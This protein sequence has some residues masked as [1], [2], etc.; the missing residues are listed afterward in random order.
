MMLNLKRVHGLVGKK[1]HKQTGWHGVFRAKNNSRNHEH[2]H[3]SCNNLYWCTRCTSVGLY[4]FSVCMDER[5]EADWFAFTKLCIHGQNGPLNWTL[6]LIYHTYSWINE[7]LPMKHLRETLML[8]FDSAF[9]CA[10]SAQCHP[11]TRSRRN[12]LPGCWAWCLT[13]DTC[14]GSWLPGNVTP[15]SPATCLDK[16]SAWTANCWWRKRVDKLFK[17]LSFSENL[18]PGILASCQRNSWISC[19]V[20]R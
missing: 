19:D 9:R 15:G 10:P 20:S 17:M 6:M 5:S 2:F 8:I 16:P 7:S 1:Q 18:L 11:V 3:F 4:N 14:S 12:R 13:S